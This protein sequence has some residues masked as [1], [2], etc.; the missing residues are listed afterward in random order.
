MVLLVVAYNSNAY[1]QWISNP[2]V[3]WWLKGLLLVGL[4]SSILLISFFITHLQGARI[5]PKQRQQLIGVFGLGVLAMAL[6]MS[7][8]WA[9]WN[10]SGYGGWFSDP[11]LAGAV[12]WLM[13]S[14]LLW[15]PVLA[16]RQTRAELT[17]TN[18]L[19]YWYWIP[20][21]IVLVWLASARP[22]FQRAYPQARLL[23]PNDGQLVWGSIGLYTLA[24]LA[25]FWA[26]EAFFRGLFARNMWYRWGINA[27][28]PTAVWYMSI[29][30]GK[31]WPEALSSLLGAYL[32]S[33]W[34]VKT[35]SIRVGVLAHLLLALGMELMG[36]I[37]HGA[38]YN[39]PLF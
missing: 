24:Y 20:A 28:L 16:Y 38:L 37:R 29:H 11:W 7:L 1:T 4:F 21:I 27:I 32:L 14:A 30:L 3:A 10:R 2:T 12:S 9:S 39:L 26:I 6:R 22:D 18:E 23:M 13:R 34:A 19:R 8:P 5:L 25:D 17:S 15:I 31:P 33:Q 35:Q 36:W